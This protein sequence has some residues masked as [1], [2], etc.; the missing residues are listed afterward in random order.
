MGGFVLFGRFR[1]WDR[2]CAVGGGPGGGGGSGIAGS[3]LDCDVD[4]ARAEIG[5]STALAEAA[6]R[7]VGGITGTTFSTGSMAGGTWIINVWG[8]DT[9][10]NERASGL[11]MESV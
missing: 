11:G 9:G 3:H 10:A 6:L 4:R 7:A 2:D 8:L 5:V 1:L